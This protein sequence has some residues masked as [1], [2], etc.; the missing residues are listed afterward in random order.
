MSGLSTDKRLLTI[1]QFVA[2]GT[3]VETHR[4]WFEVMKHAARM[5]IVRAE[6]PKENAEF[7]AAELNRLIHKLGNEGYLDDEG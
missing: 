7:A 4:N 6:R 2:G 3:S 5:Y 1:E